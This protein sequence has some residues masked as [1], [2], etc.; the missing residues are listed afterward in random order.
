MT[1]A[2]N[3]HHSVCYCAAQTTALR[4]TVQNDKYMCMDIAYSICG[5]GCWTAIGGCVGM[6]SDV[7]TISTCVVCLIV[8]H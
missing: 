3:N 5:C 4:N 7:C 1:A 2:I 6:C 8:G